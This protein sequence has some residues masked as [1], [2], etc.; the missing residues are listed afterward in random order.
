VEPTSPPRVIYELTPIGGELAAPLRDVV[1][2][3]GRRVPDIL[4]AQL[5]YDRQP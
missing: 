1:E 4:A 2:R 5:A 3:L